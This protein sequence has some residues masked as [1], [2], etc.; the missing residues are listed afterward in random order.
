MV[1]VDGGR[2][3]DLQ[4][5]VAL[6]RVLEQAVHGVQH[7]VREQEKPFSGRK[8]AEVT[9][10]TRG[11]VSLTHTAPCP[12]NAG[13]G[14]P[15]TPRCRLPC[16]VSLLPA[17]ACP[18]RQAASSSQAQAPSHTDLCPPPSRPRRTDAQWALRNHFNFTANA[19]KVEVGL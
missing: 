17:A 13:P 19:L 4:A 18:T 8:R 5:V 12:P 15:R 9:P 14:S 3:V 10:G 6:A 1:G 16:R 11:D 7:L 2:G